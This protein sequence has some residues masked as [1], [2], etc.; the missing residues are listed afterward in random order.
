M[1]NDELDRLKAQGGDAMVA[2]RQTRLP[3]LT[4]EEI[5]AIDS[6]PDDA[7]DHWSKDEIWNGSQWRKLRSDE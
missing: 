3:E 2:R 7:I 1:C 6:I 4:P 5:E